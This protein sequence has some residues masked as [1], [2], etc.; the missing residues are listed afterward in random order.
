[1]ITDEHIRA[2]QARWELQLAILQEEERRIVS[3]LEEH[4][5]R[6]AL[7]P[8]EMMDR[9][10]AARA[11]CNE[12]FQ[13]LMGSIEVGGTRGVTSPGHPEVAAPPEQGD[14][15]MLPGWDTTAGR[16]TR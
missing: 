15:A 2:A 5:R 1:M 14:P 8:H 11:Q 10:K 13:G 9:L 7:L 16:R 6:G 3:A 4:S 12:A